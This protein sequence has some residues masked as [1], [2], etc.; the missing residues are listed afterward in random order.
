MSE[1]NKEGLE[2]NFQEKTKTTTTILVTKTVFSILV[3]MTN[4]FLLREGYIRIINAPN[5]PL[6]G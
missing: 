5:Q 2:D 4:E 3:S 1:D 6:K